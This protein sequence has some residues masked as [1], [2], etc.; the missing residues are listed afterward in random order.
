MLPPH[1][2]LRRERDDALL[3]TPDAR[4]CLVDGEGCLFDLRR[5][6]FAGL[7]ES[8]TTLLQSLLRD[9]VRVTCCSAAKRLGVSEAVVR[10]DIRAVERELDTRGFLQGGTARR[11][12]RLGGIG[13]KLF[14][15]TVG[16]YLNR[17]CRLSR[18]FRTPRQEARVVRSLLRTTWFCLPVLGLSATV[19]LFRRITVTSPPK[20]GSFSPDDVDRLIQK[21]AG[22]MALS[23]AC[24]ERSLSAYFLLRARCG[25]NPKVVIGLQ[26]HPFRAHAWVTCNG[27]LLT[28]DPDHCEFFVPVAELG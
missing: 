16:P 28:D 11:G 7:N 15:L 10:E 4:F 14:R 22:R 19:D 20:R 26:R 27:H 3:L 25:L 12:V 18:S 9:G 8:A 24:K 23:V 21:E 2:C 17:L 6:R 1:L 5:G 13:R